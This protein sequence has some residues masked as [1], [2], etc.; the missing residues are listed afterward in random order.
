MIFL[1]NWNRLQDKQV[2]NNIPIQREKLA[3]YITLLAFGTNA[4]KE[5]EDVETCIVTKQ[6]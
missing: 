4:M 5:S 1:L 2:I 6:D 3:E